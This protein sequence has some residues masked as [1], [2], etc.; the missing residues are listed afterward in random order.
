MY[1]DKL[2]GEAYLSHSS[3]EI[4]LP[5][6]L[7]IFSP[8]SSKNNSY[9][10]PLGGVFPKVLQILLDNIALSVKSL[11]YISKSTSKVNQR[12]AQ[13]TFHCNLHFPSKIL[14]SI[15]SPL[16]S[17]ITFP[18]FLFISSN[19]ISRTFPVFGQIG[20][21]GQYVFFL[22][23]RRVGN[24]IFIISSYFSKTLIKELLKIPFL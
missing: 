4:P 5:F 14:V 10:K 8:F 16:L 21:K 6:D 24:I 13:S 22:S 7:E 23:S 20:K 1:I 2:S 19:G 3:M 11:P 18:D 15:F 12:M 9:A 17:K